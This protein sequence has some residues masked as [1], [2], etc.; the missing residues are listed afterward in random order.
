MPALSWWFFG[1]VALGAIVGH[2]RWKA[3]AWCSLGAFDTPN[4]RLP[5]VRNSIF[6][7]QAVFLR[8]DTV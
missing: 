2:F 1:L 7:A 8:H 5:R 4:D 6:G 3:R